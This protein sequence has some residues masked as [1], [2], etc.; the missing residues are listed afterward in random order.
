MKLV[1][2]ISAILLPHAV[3]AETDSAGDTA[4]ETLSAS[5]PSHMPADLSTMDMS[6]HSM[7]GM[8]G[9]N[10]MNREA[11][12]KNKPN[13]INSGNLFIFITPLS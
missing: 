6:R 8:F 11:V 7:H 12:S 13:S 10:S 3:M 1:W 5:E 4:L 2:L 9:P